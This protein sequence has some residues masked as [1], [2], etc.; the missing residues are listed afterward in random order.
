[1]VFSPTSSKHLTHLLTSFNLR[2]PLH[3]PLNHHNFSKAP[4]ILRRLKSSDSSGSFTDSLKLRVIG[5]R[6]GDGCISFARGPNQEIAPPDGGHGGNGG[7]V[8]LKASDRCRSLRL[9]TTH[10][11]GQHGGNGMS[12]KR[13]GRDGDDITVIVPRGTVVSEYLSRDD[14]F[15]EKAVQSTDKGD[16]EKS[17]VKAKYRSTFG[18]EEIE[19]FE[20]N[21]DP[22]NDSDILRILRE[23]EQGK[24]TPLNSD[25]TP[26]ATCSTSN[27]TPNST[28]NANVHRKEIGETKNLVCELN[29]DGQQVLVAE[30][31]KGGKG[32]VAFKSS[33]NRSP[34]KCS[35]GTAGQLRKI[36]LELK[37]I[38]DVGLVGFPNAGKSTLLRAISN[39]K[40][41][42]AAYPFTTLRPHIGMVS[43]LGEDDKMISVA[44]IPGLIEGAHEDRGLGH[45][46]LRHI[47]R[48]SVL[49]YVVDV[50]GGGKQATKALKVLREELEMYLP[51]L[52]KRASCVVANKMDVK[53]LRGDHN[54][55]KGV[56]DGLLE[57]NESVGDEFVVF[58]VSAKYGVGVSDVVDHLSHMVL[59][60]NDSDD[61]NVE[62]QGER[63]E[64]LK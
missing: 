5:G 19:K 64:E 49:V 17:D 61:G 22:D 48:T 35:P 32:N 59:G 30:S 50:A 39:A 24:K 44:D 47:E 21:D 52:S 42:V 43:C 11:R 63:Q 23:M 56:T 16:G 25:F 6:G 27:S 26:T 40:P 13:R 62:V 34:L 7:H 8:F 28:S 18:S 15:S 33:T 53:D 55:R 4:L 9:S 31:G 45:D 36:H 1:M 10:L 41:R 57:F 12:A 46:F 14:G 38:A 3:L 51:G 29:D 60:G 54:G 20:F 2:L 37:T 58:P